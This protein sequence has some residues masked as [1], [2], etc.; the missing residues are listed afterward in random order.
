MSGP[1]SLDDSGLF[2]KE[3]V[4]TKTSTWRFDG[5]HP[6]FSK[7]NDQNHLNQEP[8]A[9]NPISIALFEGPDINHLAAEVSLLLL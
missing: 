6:T 5:F 9:L 8:R 4:G 2:F 7:Q 3:N 1:Q